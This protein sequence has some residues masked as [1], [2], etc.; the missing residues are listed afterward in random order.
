LLQ[1]YY[2]KYGYGADKHGIMITSA[3]LEYTNMAL[4]VRDLL[5]I[6]IKDSEF[7][8]LCKLFNIS[9]V[10]FSDNS[11]STYN[12]FE[13]A[14]KTFINDNVKPFLTNFY[15][16]LSKKL[17]TDFILVPDFTEQNESLKDIKL[18][19]EIYNLMYTSGVVTGNEWRQIN[20]LPIE[21][22]YNGNKQITDTTNT[23]GTK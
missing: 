1:S 21:T 16:Q 17:D 15:S 19:N 14:S 10:L 8:E 7:R 9:S 6:E 12:N 23:S 3:S 18:L 4:P 5:P 11:S 13:T 20:N 22:Q 2:N